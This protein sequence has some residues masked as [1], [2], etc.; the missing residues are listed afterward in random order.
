MNPNSNGIVL[1]MGLGLLYVPCAGPVLATIAVVG[2][3][4]NVG[5]SALVL[6]AAFGIGAG[7]PLLILAL[8]GDA[9]SRR[10]GALRRNAHKLRV[11]GGILMLAVAVAIGFNLTDGLQR[12]VPGYTTALQNLVEG[13][14]GAA[15]Q[16]RQLSAD[17]SNG[18]GKVSA[19][20]TGSASGS[21]GTAKQA[22]TQCTEDGQVLEQCGTAPD[23][24]GI[25][26]WLN[27]PDG[28]PL[29]L[30]SLRGKTC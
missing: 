15:N 17:N 18:P 10:T 28:K 26:G 23:F 22:S 13:N 19:A 1:G 20:G 8:A 5:F 9:I 12:N 24:T 21:G 14:S 3:T 27:T 30:A 4:H 2:A 29:D 25:T 16:L 7:V 6:T 11:T